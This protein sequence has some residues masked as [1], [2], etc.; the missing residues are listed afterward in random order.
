MMDDKRMQ[1]IDSIE[2]YAYRTS[3]HLASEK[4]EIKCSSIIKRHKKL[5]TLTMLHKKT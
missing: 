2:T 3:G 1:T 5:L 4:E